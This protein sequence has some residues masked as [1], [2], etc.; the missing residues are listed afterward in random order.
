MSK[1]NR[2]NRKC[3]SESIGSGLGDASNNQIKAS[4][5]FNSDGIQLNKT[6]WLVYLKAH[7]WLVGLLIFMTIGALGAGLK[8]L[9]QEAHREIAGRA[10]NQPEE[11]LLNRINPFLPAALPAPSPQLSKEYIYA[12]SRILA[13]EDANAAP[14]ASADLAVWRPSSGVWWVLGGTSSQQFSLSWGQE[15]DI[16]GQGDYD[17]DGKTDLCIFRST[18][19]TWWI[20]KSSDASF[21]SVNFGAGGDSIAQ[22][23]YDGDGKTDIAVFRPSNGSWYVNQSSNGATVQRQFGLSSD[24]PAPKDFDGDGR[25]DL[26]V[27]RS[28]NSTFYSLNSSDNQMQTSSFTQSGTIPVPADYDGDGRADYAIRSGA[29]WIIRNSLTNQTQTIAW[30]QSSDIEVPNDYDGDGKVDIA[31]WRSSNGN[32]YIRKSGAGGALRQEQWGTS[33]D[34]PVPAF[35][36]R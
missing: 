17:G 11:S 3:A 33:R 18:T 19:N 21:Y 2:K 34:I 32:W 5:S 15:G 9:D 20:L 22:A 27:W 13:V 36:R 23:D 12:G 31:T 35:Y 16:P 1:K 7:L 25:A 28:S 14:A 6:G 4:G 24:T 29:D 8:Y 26:A 30:Q 10:N